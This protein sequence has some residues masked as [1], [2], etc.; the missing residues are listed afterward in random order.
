MKELRFVLAN[1]VIILL[2]ASSGSPAHEDAPAGARKPG[3]LSLPE[4]V[5]VVLSPSS[6]KVGASALGDYPERVYVPNSMDNTLQVIDPKTFKIIATYPVGEQPHHVTPSWDLTRLYVNNT[7]G[8]SLTVIDPLTG[9]IAGVIP[10][11]DPYNLYFTPDGSKAIVVAEALYRLDIRNPTTWKLIK[12]IP[13]RWAG[14]DH[15]AFS[16]DGKYLVASCE[17][18]GRIVKVDL[19]KLEVAAD[20]AIGQNPIDVVRPPGQSAMFVADQGTNGVY[21]V[22][23]DAWKILDFIPTGLGTHGILLSRDLK[24]VY[25]SNRMEGTIS[26]IDVEARKVVATWKTG[27]TPDMGQLSPDGKQLWISS[28]Y[29]ED[30]RVIDTDTGK[31]IKRIATGIGP[32]GLTYFPNSASPHSLGHNGVY[33]EDRPPADPLTDS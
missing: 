25:A 13:I 33:V 16:Q 9:A 3:D 4:A 12:S 20:M 23:P 15:L 7:R 24:H 31:L 32:H 21:V 28:R 1:A 17:W 14:V 2:L 30:V 6:H 10:V 29:N 26:V 11:P 8:N 18:A 19:D 22:D 27:G 5:P